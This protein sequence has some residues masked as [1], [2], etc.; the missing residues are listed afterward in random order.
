[1]WFVSNGA[2]KNSL[3]SSW[4]LFHSYLDGSRVIFFSVQR[5]TAIIHVVTI[6][7]SLRG[8]SICNENPFITSSTDVLVFYAICQV[9][10]AIFQ[11]K[12]QSTAV[13][14]VH[15]TLFY[16]TSFNVTN[17]HCIYINCKD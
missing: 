9:F 12:D 13:K 5:L 1:M 17:L 7:G 11:T 8:G 15:K 2:S 16:L 3:G 14:M 10:Y 4:A 6:V